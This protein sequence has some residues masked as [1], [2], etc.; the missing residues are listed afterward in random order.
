MFSHFDVPTR[1]M[2]TGNLSMILCCAFYLAWWIIA[3]KPVGAIKGMKSGWLLFPAFVFGI[4]GIAMIILGNSKADSENVLFPGM[5]ALIIGIVAY[6]VLLAATYF[7]LK[8]QVTTELLLIVGWTVL[9]FVEMN[10]LF[11]QGHFSKLPTIILLAIT[12][13]AAVVSLVCY[14]L[15][16]NLGG[17]AGYVDGMIPLIIVAVMMAVVTVAVVAGSLG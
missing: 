11:A 16:Y 15:Y 1:Q 14:L 9:M 13:V 7:I 2:L 3:F 12:L 10:A 6:V 8:R 4:A 17:V 5:A